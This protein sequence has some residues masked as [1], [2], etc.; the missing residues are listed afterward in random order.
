MDFDRFKKIQEERPHFGEIE[1]PDAEGTFKNTSCGD[2][3]RITLR[4]GDGGIIRDARFTTTGCGFGL[5]ALSAVCD[6]ALGKTID[7]A[8]G[9]VWEDI[10]RAIGGFPPKR[11]HYPKVA[12]VAFQQALDDYRKKRG[13]AAG[14][15]RP[16]SEGARSAPGAL[17][18]PPL[19]R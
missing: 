4:I 3:Y 8:E 6:L 19:R 15:A 16:V 10:D 14:A 2:D 5:A 17:M 12:R 18:P 11:L 1:G 9:L 7:E 13:I